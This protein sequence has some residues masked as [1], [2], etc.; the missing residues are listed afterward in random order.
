[1]NENRPLWD[2][3]LF[4]LAFLASRRSLD[5]HTRQGCIFTDN[6]HRIL[7]TGYN[8]PPGGLDDTTLPYNRPLTDDPNEP[9]KYDWM[10]H[11]EENALI[12][13]TTNLNYVPGGVTAYITG[14]PCHHCSMLMVENNI[15][16]MKIAKRTGT[17]K[18]NEKSRANFTRLMTEKRIEVTYVTPDLS[19]IYN[20]N[21]LEEV[22]KLGFFPTFASW[23]ICVIATF[24]SLPSN[25]R[26]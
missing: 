13:T 22:V 8:N 24:R 5:P 19:W 10:I 15:V 11:A 7:A 21:E 20:S 2:D 12:N 18:E 1:M 14:Q 4:G 9:S 17:L 6:K 16:N 3:Y 25:R 23:L 26:D